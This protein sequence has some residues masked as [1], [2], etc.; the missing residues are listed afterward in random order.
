MQLTAPTPAELESLLLARLGLKEE[1]KNSFLAPEYSFGNLW[2]FSDMKKAVARL[3][4]AVTEG[5]Q[6]G[7]YADYDCDGIP[8]A[9][10]LVDLFKK[11]GV[12]DR[13]HLYIPDRHDEGY[14]VSTLGIDA[15]D[16]KKVTLMITVDV[17]ITAIAQIADA[18]SRVIDVILTDHH[19]PLPDLPAA[20]A[21]VHPSV[22]KYKNQ[23]PCGAAMAFYLVLAFLEKYRAEFEIP[24]GWEKW[25]LDLVGFATLSDMVP[26]TGENRMLA[27]Y[28]MHVMRKTRRIGIQILLDKNNI[29]PQNLTESDLTFTLAPRLNAASRM[30]SPL[31]AFEL[32]S[33]EDKNK[34]AEIVKELDIINNE[35]NFSSTNCKICELKSRSETDRRGIKRNSSD[36]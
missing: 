2:D 15:L 25:L 20:Y 12:M 3:Y 36:R 31:L 28:G 34:A 19:A 10:I 17:G 5:E 33:T 29:N 24:E 23:D 32:L 26:L 6:I 30:A 13:V 4:K 21:V 18:Q 22:G 9:V 11:L 7:I 27:A 35:R 1:E 8:G 14:G 16:A